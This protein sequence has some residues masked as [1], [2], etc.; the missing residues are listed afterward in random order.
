MKKKNGKVVKNT[1]L[2]DKLKLIHRNF[3]LREPTYIDRQRQAI[4][5]WYTLIL[6]VGIVSNL[7][8][9]SGSFVWFFKWSNSLLLLLTLLW[10]FAYVIRKTSIRTTILLMA[11]ST[12]TFIAL[13]TIYCAVDMTVPN[14][15][16][17]ILMN[18]LILVTNIIFSLATYQIRVTQIITA[19]AVFS[20]VLCM[21]LTHNKPL[22]EYF[23]MMFL[24][25]FFIT[26]LGLRIARNG[27]RLQRENTTLKK[28]EE[29]LLHILRLNKQQVKAYIRL[30]KEEYSHDKTRLLLE[31]FDEK[32]Q[33]NI[34]ANVTEFLRVKATDDKRIE[35][36]F[37]ELTR[38]RE[39][40]AN[41]CCAT[42]NSA[43]SVSC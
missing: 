33:K 12:Q 36:V 9:I 29:E 17:V 20:Y 28:D 14:N 6:S 7:L 42:V 27:E 5:V 23:F 34:I 37:P 15:Q 30:A 39:I 10:E 16:M 1:R 38:L 4:A 8:E 35:Q 19:I 21:A 25:F 41:W 3:V 22:Q 26:V 40:F 11:V 2:S 13:D 31:Q 18:M 32:S 43:K 24:V